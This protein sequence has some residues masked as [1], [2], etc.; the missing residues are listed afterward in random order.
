MFT[1]L[2]EYKQTQ[3]GGEAVIPFPY[4][5]QKNTPKPKR[6]RLNPIGLSGQ[7]PY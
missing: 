7:T 4:G 3:A 1:P 2:Q 6:K 5:S